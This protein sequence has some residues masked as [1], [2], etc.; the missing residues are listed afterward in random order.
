MAKSTPSVGQIIKRIHANEIAP[1]YSLFGN[2]SFLQDFFIEELS[3]SFLNGNEVKK[4]IS[5]DD[6]RQE[7]LLSELSSVSLFSERQLLVV[8]QIK[9]LSQNGRKEL[10]EYLENPNR[11]ICLVLI[12]EDYD[13]RNAL[14][15]K[16]K[17]NTLFLD[18]RVPFPSKM[19]EWVNF[20]IK[21]KKYNV[22]PSVIENMID[23]YGDSIAHVINEIEKM[24][25]MIGIENELNDQVL[26]SHLSIQREFHLWQFQDAIGGKNADYSITIINSL[27][28]NGTKIP[29]IAIS[30]TNLF[31]QML[32]FHMGN[33]HQSG[34]TGL[35]K[36]ITN[37]LSKYCRLYSQQE[38]EDALLA[39]RK[40]DL[41]TK[42]TS[43]S[44][45]ALVE[46]LI[47]QMCK[48]E[49]V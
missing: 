25:L 46:P 49:Y 9:K 37:N 41:L 28:E 8:R 20:I 23:S 35:N 26:S 10:L 43:I 14:Q 7:Y 32:W 17:E 39:L 6:D 30:L 1:A 2:E 27:I 38:V 44:D 40:I 31:Q 45:I 11:D 15:K 18:V 36:I 19:K 21:N 42:S 47:I 34:Y 12:S 33:T 3:K 4:H 22:N 29:Q 13:D 5:L 48:G 16:L 24:V